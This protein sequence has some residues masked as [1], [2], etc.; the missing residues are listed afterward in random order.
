MGG[1]P[2]ERPARYREVSPIERIPL[3]VPV[4]LVHGD[5]DPIVPVSQSQDF[6]GLSVA[7]NVPADL[8]VVAGAGHFELTDP[9][10]S[11]W[12]AVLRAARALTDRPAA[13]TPRP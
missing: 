7:A 11:A 6:V 3:G 9:K 12:P 10:S 2:G 8:E 5:A 4:R 13:P 1:S